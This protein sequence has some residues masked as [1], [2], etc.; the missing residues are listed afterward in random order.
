MAR[1]QILE[2]W[3]ILNIRNVREVIE[4]KLLRDVHVCVG[5]EENKHSA[6]KES[7]CSCRKRIF[8]VTVIECLRLP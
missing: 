1:V 3:L 6:H 4:V 2:F 5:F 7:V 8:K